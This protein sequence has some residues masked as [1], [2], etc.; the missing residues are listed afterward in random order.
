MNCEAAGNTARGLALVGMA[1]DLAPADLNALRTDI[2]TELRKL[3]S[4]VLREEIPDNMAEQLDRL[5]E[6]IP[7]GPGR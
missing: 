4:E 6:A 7:R 3:Y 1:L 2:G 5:M